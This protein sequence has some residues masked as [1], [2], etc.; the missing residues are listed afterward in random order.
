MPVIRGRPR[1]CRQRRNLLPA[2]SA[3]EQLDHELPRQASSLSSFTALKQALPQPEDDLFDACSVA[4][5]ETSLDPDS[6]SDSDSDDS[7]NDSDDEDSD[8]DSSGEG[9]AAGH[10][11][12][13]HHLI[14]QYEE[15]GPVLANRGDSAK[16]MIR[17]EERK[18]IKFCDVLTKERRLIDPA[19]DPVDPDELLKKCHAPTFKAYL[20]WRCKNSR[21]KKESSIITY[22]KVLSMFYS[23]KCATWMDGKILFDIGNVLNQDIFA[24][25]ILRAEI[26]L[27]LI[28]AG[29]TATRPGALI[30][31]L[32][33]R[34]AF[35]QSF[36]S[37]SKQQSSLE[38]SFLSSPL[39]VCQANKITTSLASSPILVSDDDDNNNQPAWVPDNNERSRIFKLWPQ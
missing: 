29:A 20:H 19:A 14:S 7:S 12:S 35:K 26:A 24:H 8:G 5:S 11:T 10:S 6:D 33:Y 17:T 34:L 27:A 18:W 31:R 1:R 21:I 37:S 23:D 36:S 16:K 3:A 32:C 2:A 15:E 39:T 30:E 22:W 28:V 38:S 9:E 13:Y 4:G 25:E